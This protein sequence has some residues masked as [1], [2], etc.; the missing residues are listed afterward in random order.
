MRQ[1]YFAS[2]QST[3]YLKKI[4]DFWTLLITI[5]SLVCILVATLFPFNFSFEEGISLNLIFNSFYHPSNLGDRL[6]NI[7][8]FIPFGFGVACL[9]SGKKLGG[10]LGF[11]IVLLTSIGLSLTVEILQI[12]LPMRSSSIADL[13]TNTIGGNIG[14]FCAYLWRVQIF[15]LIAIAFEKCQ[16]LYSLKL[17]TIIFISYFSLMSLIAVALQKG[18]N[19]SNW[20]QDFFLSLG[21][22]TADIYHPWKGN[23]S[24]LE[25][26]DR[27][28]SLEEIEKAFSQQNGLNFLGDSLI[29][30]YPL[31]DGQYSDKTQHSPSLTWLGIPPNNDRNLGVSLSSDGWLKTAEP[32]VAIAQKLSKSSQFTISAILTT[33]D[34][35][36]R[37]TGNIITF[38]SDSDPY[39]S[40]FT[41]AQQETDLVFRMRSPVTGN[42]GTYPEIVVPDVFVDLK[43]Y[44][45]IITYDGL[46]LR[47]YIDRVE[48]I[49]SLDLSPNITFFRYLLYFWDGFSIRL[50]RTKAAYKILYY[51]IIFVPL[52]IILGLIF[53]LIKGKSF[54]YILFL[55]SGIILPSFI[56]EG[57][58][59][60][61]NS[62][63]LSQENIFLSLSIISITVLLIKKISLPKLKNIY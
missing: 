15:T 37:G 35:F 30:S 54:F 29:A 59:V 1:D 3:I 12:F 57:A 53:K 14:F 20:Q 19:L 38:S 50:D 45:I 25:I 18:T 21:N 27:A 16:R 63:I 55:L 11:A 10:L 6:R 17:L 58:S 47:F 48:S 36:Q 51:G 49:Y 44:H 60:K 39:Q 40:N 56:L 33:A 52:G 7:L 62:M 8:L 5:S 31:I 13:V 41:L 42:N 34:P 22:E 28:L 43:P 32:A 4:V 61:G 26:A 9:I 24:Q 2:K 46:A 23:I